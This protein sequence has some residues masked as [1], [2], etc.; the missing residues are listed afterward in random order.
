MN[1]DHSH[2]SCHGGS[3]SFIAWTRDTETCAQ[4]LIAWFGFGFV[5]VGPVTKSIY[6]TW[7]S[8]CVPEGVP[9]CFRILNHQLVNS[10]RFRATP[11]LTIETHSLECIWALP[12]I[13]HKW[14]DLWSRYSSW[15]TFW[16]CKQKKNNIWG[17]TQHGL[18]I[19][20]AWWVKSSTWFV[21]W[22]EYAYKIVVVFRFQYTQGVM[23]MGL[24]CRAKTSSQQKPL[25]QTSLIDARSLPA[26]SCCSART[27]RSWL[28]ETPH[29][30][31]PEPSARGHTQIPLSGHT[32]QFPDAS[33]QVRYIAFIEFCT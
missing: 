1:K 30:W 28:P 33:R 2:C 24:R 23:Y 6:K 8:Y 16:F 29:G 3:G 11:T 27:S 18:L 12:N 19:C 17:K 10:Q 4:I 25:V 32:H 5:V 22:N 13:M 20:S 14:C 31:Q 7:W 26:D 21:W 9:S 15:Y